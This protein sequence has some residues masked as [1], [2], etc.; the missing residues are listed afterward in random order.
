MAG[1]GNLWAP[2]VFEFRATVKR[3]IAIKIRMLTCGIALLI[4][5]AFCWLGFAAV[6]FEPLFQGFEDYIPVS[7]RFAYVHRP[8]LFPLFGLLGAAG[9]IIADT[10]LLRRYV[11]L[12]L[13]VFFTIIF[14]WTFR[15]MFGPFISLGPA[16]PPT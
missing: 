14:I 12:V 8:I 2:Q 13:I 7:K 9:L 11:Q 1:D 5:V 6:R 15:S 16:L 3:N 4:L 10:F